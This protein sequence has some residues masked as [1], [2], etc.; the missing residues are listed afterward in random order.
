MEYT[1]SGHNVHFPHTAYGIQ[2]AFMGKVL[3]TLDR[4]DNALLEAPTGSGK[5]LSLLCAA[6]QW[7]KERKENLYRDVQA[8]ILPTETQLEEGVENDLKTKSPKVFYATRTHAQIHQVVQE[9]KRTN[10]RPKTA[11]LAA[12][13]H[14][15]VNSRVVK[16]GN[17]QENCQKE[18]T[19]GQCMYFRNA[20]SLGRYNT[21]IM[22]IED[23]VKLGKNMRA[24]PYFASRKMA[25]TAELVFCPYNYLIDPDI[26]DSMGITV[27]GDVIIFDEAHNIEDISRDSATFKATTEDLQT[28]RLW[29]QKNAM[30]WE[31]EGPGSEELLEASRTLERQFGIVLQELNR[32]LGAA[33]VPS[34]RSWSSRETLQTLERMGLDQ[35]GAE[36]LK[37]AYTKLRSAREENKKAMEGQAPQNAGGVAASQYMAEDGAIPLQIACKLATVLQLLYDSSPQLM[38]CFQLT[39][40]SYI[41]TRKE[42]IGRFTQNE[43]DVQDAMVEVQIMCLDPSV[44]FS[45]LQN[46]THAIILTSGTLSPMGSF[47]SELGAD[48]RQ[49]ME[50]GHVVNMAKQVWAGSCGITSDNARVRFVYSETSKAE[51]QD[52][53]GHSLVEWCKVIPDGVLVFMPSYSLLDKLKQR[54]QASGVLRKLTAVKPV[55]QEPRGGGPQFDETIQKYYAS[56]DKG[57]G[58]IFLG[59]CRGKASEG[60]NF[61]DG[62]ARSVVM[63][64]IPFPNIKDCSVKLKRGYNDHRRA[65][66]KLSGGQWY[67]QQAFRALNQGVG[68]CIRHRN[69]YGA[70][71]LLDERFCEP[72]SLSSVSRWV[73]GAVRCFN[74]DFQEM[75]KSAQAFFATA[76]VE[77]KPT[78]SKRS[79]IDDRKQKKRKPAI[80]LEPTYGIAKYFSANGVVKRENGGEAPAT[81]VDGCRGLPTSFCSRSNSPGPPVPHHGVKPEPMGRPGMLNGPE[82]VGGWSRSSGPQIQS[83]QESRVEMSFRGQDVSGNA[84]R[85]TLDPARVDVRSEVDCSDEVVSDWV[86]S[87][88]E[89][90]RSFLKQGNVARLQL[91]KNLQQVAGEGILE[92][93]YVAEECLTSS[94]GDVRQ[95]CE[96]LSTEWRAPLPAGLLQIF[97]A[98]GVDCPG[99]PMPRGSFQNRSY[100]GINTAAEIHR[101]RGAYE[102]ALNRLQKWDDVSFQWGPA[103]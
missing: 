42:R 22:D 87:D 61:S 36:L 41:N 52:R 81:K 78:N 48:F 8:Q 67:E 68:R 25:Q 21:D 32:L 62:Y 37:S 66:G 43:D 89:N 47:A 88:L 95:G 86:A 70:I 28:A 91:P 16:S 44:I 98:Q 84:R 10:Y 24:C 33:Q 65:N 9:M 82:G 97:F 51:V 20:D 46:D 18:L 1:I 58:G 76:S 11:I 15:C 83:T 3:E 64:G 2:L 79:A 27:E 102:K 50:G 59:V 56:I 34:E 31:R 19:D 103:A 54:W 96:K 73:R 71:L 49:R 13:Q 5:T 23:L 26:R 45:K 100:G 72:Q 63:I 90:Y 80:S 29:F 30:V 69:D 39:S 74:M 7:L 12:K 35:Q 55:F 4:G 75:V 94:G 57:R 93:F 17:I 53:V 101:M 77:F 6:S 99:H 60:M 40:R 14:Y 92:A 38:Q 85:A